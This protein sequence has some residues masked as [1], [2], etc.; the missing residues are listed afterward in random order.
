MLVLGI[1]FAKDLNYLSQL[2]GLQTLHLFFEGNCSR[3]SSERGDE[4]ERRRK[5][6]SC[7]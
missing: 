7:D 1:I 5:D 2:F 6:S 4:L 3:H